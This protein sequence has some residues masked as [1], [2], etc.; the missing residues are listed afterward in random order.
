VT[1]LV[2]LTSRRLAVR[3]YHGMWI[4]DCPFCK[5][6][7]R[8]RPWDP[9]WQCHNCGY[10]CTVVWPAPR[11]AQGVMRLLAMRPYQEHRNWDPRETLHDLM[12]QNGANGLY[13]AIEAAPGQVM[14]SVDDEGIRV[15]KLQIAAGGRRLEVD[16]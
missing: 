4:V 16:A 10:D 1:E 3:V 6:A 8:L 11:F 13:D 12:F 14:L 9:Y 7:W 15:D 2:G 5:N